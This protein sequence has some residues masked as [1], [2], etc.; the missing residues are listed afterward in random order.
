[1]KKLFIIIGLLTAGF[2]AQAQTTNLIYKVTV[3]VV[4]AGVTN[5][6]NATLKL[7]NAVKR[8]AFLIAGV[9]AAF[10]KYAADGGALAF[11]NWLKTDIK[12]RLAEYGK[13]KAALDNEATAA[14]IN[15]L[16]TLNPDLLST[17]DVNNLATIA[18]KAP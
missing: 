18:A 10:A 5:S 4:T 11:D 13:V 8:D 17:A 3:E 9:G 1:M 14:K 6:S 16:L 2:T 12:D 15:S 7:D